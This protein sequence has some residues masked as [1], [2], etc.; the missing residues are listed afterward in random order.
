MEAAHNSHG[1]KQERQGMLI[2]TATVNEEDTG[3]RLRR[4]KRWN[5][6]VKSK[7]EGCTSYMYATVE[8]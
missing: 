3:Y 6:S 2:Q 1:T 5:N 7:L 8:G 4:E